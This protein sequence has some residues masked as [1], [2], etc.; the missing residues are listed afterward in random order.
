MSERS[1]V[2]K[3]LAALQQYQQEQEE[4]EAARNRPKANWLNGKILADAGGSLTGRFLQE[5]DEDSPNYDP[6][7]GVGFI[8]VEHQAPGNEGYKRRGL[9]TL[10]SEGECYACERHKQ[11]YQEGWRQRSNLYINF[12]AVVDGELKVFVVARNANSTFAKSLI[13]ETVDE[14][15]ITDANYRITKTGTGTKTEWLLKR[16]KGEPIDVSSVEPWDLDEVAL[17]EVEYAKQAD[18]YGAVYKG[19]ATEGDSGSDL[20]AAQDSAD[21]EW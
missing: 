17:R 6:E 1:S 5:L 4:K 3:G 2:K 14:G 7:K 13:Q 15:S 20:V 11:N 8:A 10:E 12:A 18:Y 19:G 16:V 21:A 9:C